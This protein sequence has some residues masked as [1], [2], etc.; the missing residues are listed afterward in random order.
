MAISVTVAPVSSSAC[1][2]VRAFVASTAFM[3]SL[4]PVSVSSMRLSNS[5]SVAAWRDSPSIE[6]WQ[7]EQISGLAKKV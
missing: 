2:N 1:V 7:L 4:I 6:V 5:D 3:N